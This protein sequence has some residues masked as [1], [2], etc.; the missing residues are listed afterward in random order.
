[1]HA[2]LQ[3]TQSIPRAGTP[4]DIAGLAVFL[5][6]PASNYVTGQCIASDGGWTT[7]ARWPFEPAQ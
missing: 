6:A 5:A 1:M 3:A 7:T 2:W 4:E